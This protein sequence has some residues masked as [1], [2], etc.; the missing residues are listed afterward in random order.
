MRFRSI[1]IE[2]FRAFSGVQRIDLD[3]AVIIL[4]GPN[5]Q[6]KTSILDA[7]LWA[8]T[9]LVSRVG[10]DAS[11]LISRYSQSGEASVRLDLISGSGPVSIQRSASGE[12]S[13]LH[14]ETPSSSCSGRAAESLVSRL[15][16]VEEGDSV[17][18]TA[19][20]MPELHSAVTKSV[21]LQQDLVRGFLEAEDEAARFE[22][23]AQLVGLHALT[24]VQGEL[25]R[26]K[27][28][29]T[30]ATNA[31]REDV[32][33]LEGTLRRLNAA[34]EEVAP[35][36]ESAAFDKR[37]WNDW[38]GAVRESGFTRGDV[39]DPDSSD[40]A[41]SLDRAIREI[42]MRRRQLERRLHDRGE[43]VDQ[44]LTFLHSVPSRT[45]IGIAKSER[46][47]M[48]AR[49]KLK[50]ARN[51]LA[52][53]EGELQAERLEIARLRDE[54]KERGLLAQLALRHLGERCPVCEQEYD[55]EE[56]KVRLMQAAA[57]MPGASA[58]PDAGSLEGVRTRV[59]E[60]EREVALAEKRLG[61]A[62]EAEH[63]RERLQ[64]QLVTAGV[65]ELTSLSTEDCVRSLEENLKSLNE[66]VEGLRR[67]QE[68]GEEL[69]LRVA[70]SGEVA[71]W[72]ALLNE[73]RAVEE[74]LSDLSRSICLRD[75]AG[76]LA[77]EI[78]EGIRVGG[79]DLVGRELGRIAPLAQRIYSAI[80]PHPAFRRIDLVASIFRGRGR[81]ATHITDEHYGVSVERP[82]FILSSSQANALALAVF[83]ALNLTSRVPR[84]HSLIL[85][86]PLQSLDDINLLG[87]IDLLRRLRVARQLIVSTHDV[88]FANLLERKLRPVGQ[89]MVTRVVH[90][91]S[92]SRR[93]PTVTVRDVEY[94]RDMYIVA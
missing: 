14:V 25:E 75:E 17:D 76:G 93:G 13:R 28:S 89:D 61:A 16:G 92:W 19:Y 72:R 70:R 44:Y 30:K 27:A 36:D 33:S 77:Q 48:H 4:T 63:E 49:Q 67:L 55:R 20:A 53:T 58:I 78:I 62:M 83:I 66:A 71:R 84:F 21:Y 42:D 73:R 69:S 90:V 56:T 22:T 34:I 15:F 68:R 31:R 94:R 38:W 41:L 3:A 8:I 9:G 37:G 91:E 65:G 7:I 24:Q 39:P 51:E 1:T 64:T 35:F 50:E 88:R 40:A 43:L 60:L 26:Q 10:S 57:E 5:G 46:L 82:E 81:V 45:S 2:G 74:S 12:S 79:Q 23:L 47:A 29:W 59:Y 54:A 80:E 18:G 32:V 86:D 11:Y 87:F 52:R 6:G 85:D